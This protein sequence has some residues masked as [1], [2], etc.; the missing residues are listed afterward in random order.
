MAS[1]TQ[2]SNSS[3]GYIIRHAAYYTHSR[4]ALCSVFQQPVTHADK[5]V[6]NRKEDKTSSLVHALAFTAG[7]ES[8]PIDQG[9][10]EVGLLTS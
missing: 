7:L 3:K 10:V 9:A 8:D 6:L 4:E 1:F 2:Q 5:Q